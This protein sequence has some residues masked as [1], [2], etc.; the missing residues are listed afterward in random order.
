M[1]SVNVE[2]IGFCYKWSFRY[3]RRIIRCKLEV[4]IN[5][6]G[7]KEQ[8]LGQHLAN[9]QNLCWMAIFPRIQ[10]ILTY[11][12]YIYIHAS[13]LL[14]NNQWRIFHILTSEDIDDVWNHFLHWIYYN[15]KRWKQYCTHSLRS[16][17]RIL[18]SSL[19]DKIHI[20]TPLCNILY[21]FSNSIWK[22]QAGL[23][24]SLFW[25][26][27]W[28]CRF[29]YYSFLPERYGNIYPTPFFTLNT[30]LDRNN[31]NSSDDTTSQK[32]TNFNFHG[33]FFPGIWKFSLWLWKQVSYI[34]NAYCTRNKLGGK[35]GKRWI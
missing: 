7:R 35:Y 1:A 34:S 20:I 9:Q 15:K 4:I 6:G 3:S 5:N 28:A 11:Y 10:C 31:Q 19:E 30:M 25:K 2:T 26:C 18:F 29:P 22:G 17:P 27:S 23:E 21:I 32:Q 8:L 16:F 33:L 13:V 12:I 14:E 24:R